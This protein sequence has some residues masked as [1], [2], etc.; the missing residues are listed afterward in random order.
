MEKKKKTPEY[1]LRAGRKYDEANARRYG[2]K[3]NVKT[4]AKAIAKLDSVPNVQAYIKG[5]INKDIDN[6]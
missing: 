3:L 5:L 4:D 2:L 1:Q 6:E